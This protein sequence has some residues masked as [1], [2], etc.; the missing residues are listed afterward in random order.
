M[1]DVSQTKFFNLQLEEYFLTVAKL[2][3][4]PAVYNKEN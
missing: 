2:M 4:N 3:E 1:R